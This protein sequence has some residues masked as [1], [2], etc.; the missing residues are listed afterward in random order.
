[1]KSHLRTRRVKIRSSGLP[2]MN[3]SIRKQL[4]KRYKLLIRARQ[5]PKGSHAWLEYKKARNY[6]A[7]LLGS[8][9]TKCWLWKFNGATSSKDFWKTVRSFERKREIKN[10]GP[11]RDSS[12][13]IH[14]EDASEA[15]TLNS[16][17]VNVRKSLSNSTKEDS[18]IL[19]S[20]LASN[21]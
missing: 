8:A 18:S 20:Q 21:K 15:N 7:K 10:I 9:E 16:F 14:S 2:W 17:F 19:S 6:Y 11:I 13:V 3:S 4:N 1:M 12:G 5:T